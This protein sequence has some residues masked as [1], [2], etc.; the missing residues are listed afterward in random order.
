MSISVAVTLEST[1]DKSGKQRTGQKRDKRMLA[2]PGQK[3]KFPEKMWSNQHPPEITHS[4]RA[5]KSPATPPVHAHDTPPLD[6]AGDQAA[7]VDDGKT[8]SQDHHKQNR[9]H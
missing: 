2:P 9:K 8:R 3:N 7:H 4:K 1:M 6:A 5:G